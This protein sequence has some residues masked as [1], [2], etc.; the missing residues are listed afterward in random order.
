[1][2]YGILS[3]LLPMIIATVVGFAGT[4]QKESSMVPTLDEI[5]ARMPTIKELTED[6]FVALKKKEKTK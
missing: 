2:K 5:K 6:D 3:V 1:M 4:T